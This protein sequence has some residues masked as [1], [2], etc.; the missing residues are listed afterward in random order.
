MANRLYMF[1]VS[2][3][4]TVVGGEGFKN[5]GAKAFYQYPLSTTAISDILTGARFL[6][7]APSLLWNETH[8]TISDYNEGIKLLTATLPTLVE[9]LKGSNLPLDPRILQNMQMVLNKQRGKFILTEYTELASIKKSKAKQVNKII[10]NMTQESI[11]FASEVRR[12]VN[13]RKDKKR[14]KDFIKV[15]EKYKKLDNNDL[16]LRGFVTETVYGP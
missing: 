15:L 8:G 9:M 4:P 12:A 14:M 5:V 1:T 7:Q 3:I 6:R 11:K 2:K 16:G 10:V 13:Q